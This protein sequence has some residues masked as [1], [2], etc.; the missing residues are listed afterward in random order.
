MGRALG[1]LL[2]LTDEPDGPWSVRRLA[3]NL[4]TSPATVHRIFGSFESRSLLTRDEEGGYLP[5][6]ELFRLCRALQDNFAPIGLAHPHLVRLAEE[7][8]EATLLG[9]YEP[10]R[11]EMMFIDVVR[12]AHP[13]QYDVSPYTWLPIHSGATGLAILAFLPEDERRAIY[14]AGLSRLTNAT[15]V[16]AEELEAACTRI[17]ERGYAISVA[18]RLSGAVGISAPVHD[19]AGDVFG[20]VS[21]TMPEQRFEPNWEEPMAR[22]VLAT[23][24]QVTEELRR[25]GYRRG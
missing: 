4:G 1:V 14:R 8:G 23:A 6:P 15:L 5:A 11:R 17:R 20:D 7:S 12:A 3:R 19:S 2:A 16:T 9:A 21:V 24:A 10:A 25:A 18:Q 22:R 13:L